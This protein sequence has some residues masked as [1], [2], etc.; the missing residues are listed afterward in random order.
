VAPDLPGHGETAVVDGLD[1]DRV[2]AWLQDVVTAT[3][4]A[5][6]CLVGRVVG[7]AI[8]IAACST[9]T[10]LAGQLVL[11]DTLGLTPFDPAP[12]FGDA[13]HRFM[14]APSLTTHERLMEYCS[15]DLPAVRRRLGAGWSAYAAYAVDRASD[16]ARNAAIG[17]VMADFGMAPLPEASLARLAVPTT[18]VWGRHDL[19]TPL[20]VA[21]AAS[22]ELG[23]PLHVIDGAADD[24]ALDQP[25]AFLA[26]I[27]QILGTGGT[28]P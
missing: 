20:R 28:T 4:S 12:P 8:A 21:E 11:V 18:L 13:L 27:R 24:P 25:D 22:R 7:G 26:V 5:P 16:P 3:C 19:V 15:Y 17:T 6:P 2:L 9:R 14:E 23:W 1:R 10:E